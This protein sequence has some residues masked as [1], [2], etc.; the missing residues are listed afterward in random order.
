MGR[1]VQ[2]GGI[3]VKQSAYPEY[4]PSGVEWLAEVPVHWDVTRLKVAATYR[5]SNVDKVPAD[6]ETPVRLCNYTDVYYHDYICPE[7]DLME[8]TATPQEINRFGLQKGDILITKDSE[9]WSDIANPALV[10]KS[11]PN[12]VCGYHL[13]I[14][15]P[16][17]K[18]LVGKFLLRAFQSSIVNQQYQV[19]A[20]GV[21]RYGLPNSSIGEA[22]IPLPSLEEQ[23]VISDFLDR[24]TAKIDTL[25]AKKRTLIE[26]LKE[27]TTALISHTVT[28]GLP[29]DAARAVG[30]NPQ[31]KLK[32]TGIK[33]LRD[34]PEHWEV[35]RL[36]QISDVITVGVVV[37]PS[38]YVAP[39]GVP[40]L[41]G[42]NVR[43]FHID[44]TKSKRC[45]VH[46]SNGPLLKSR[47]TAGDVVVV[48][49]GYPGV[50]AVVPKDLEGANCASMM[51]VRRHKRFASQWLAYAFNSQPGR[52]QIDLV[53]Y[54][55]AQKQFNVSHA[56]D[57]TFAFPPLSEQR[58]IAE[59]LDHET[60]KIGSLVRTIETAIERLHE[61]R[62]SL[63][64]A[65]VTGKFDAKGDHTSV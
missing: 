59:F 52:D 8:A 57:F 35:K 23:Q 61:Y 33:W 12:L 36:R 10:V 58:A 29:P 30:L 48:R 28:R 39:T 42:G 64:T 26:R 18:S 16:N 20:T 2:G 65:A 54:G 62:A 46:V 25:V 40:F 34:V 17:T 45:P 56:V 55:A 27:Q 37:N 32:P 53:Q 63:I 24:E 38:S 19:A 31:S 5:V 1:V 3:V 41:L 6:D 60:G 11:A 7:M 22:W 14:I 21:T 13:A 50:A 47:L 51:I 44:A 43:E 4:K 9:H 49:V 15:R